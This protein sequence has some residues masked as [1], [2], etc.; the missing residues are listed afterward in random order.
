M[1]TYFFKGE[2]P[3]SCTASSSRDR[4]ANLRPAANL[5]LRLWEV[6]L[7]LRG[8]SGR[9]AAKMSETQ[10]SSASGLNEKLKWDQTRLTNILK[11][12]HGE[13]SLYHSIMS[14]GSR[15]HNILPRTETIEHGDPYITPPHQTPV[16]L[17][18]DDD[19]SASSLH[20]KLMKNK[21]GK[22]FITPNEKRERR[23]SKELSSS[24]AEAM[25]E[26]TKEFKK[27]SMPA[28]YDMIQQCVKIIMA[29]DLTM[30]E[31]ARAPDLI[32]KDNAYL[33][34]SLDPCGVLVYRWT[35]SLNKEFIIK[36]DLVLEL[37]PLDPDPVANL[38]GTG[39]SAT[40]MISVEVFSCLG[41]SQ[42]G[43][44]L[45]IGKKIAGSGWMPAKS[46]RNQGGPVEE[47]GRTLRCLK[48]LK[49][50]DE[51]SLINAAKGA[52]VSAI[53]GE[54]SVEGPRS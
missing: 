15:Q 12:E 18:K 2:N 36:M 47:P 54:V 32:R 5:P 10:A 31:K 37:A 42:T 21:N 20:F 17:T 43:L 19:S 13:E 46:E 27:S 29:M 3:A 22:D 40:F 33:C 44:H 35:S 51:T 52:P 1:S 50:R 48:V 30:L 7:H 26:A 34:C 4:W 6:N 24:F 41:R 25:V 16:D 49:E 38:I 28:S 9:P 14:D 8:S 11:Q 23:R 39:G 45:E 53:G